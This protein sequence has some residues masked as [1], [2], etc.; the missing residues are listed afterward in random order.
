M[1]EDHALLQ[2]ELRPPKRSSPLSLR[3]DRPRQV[4]RLLLSVIAVAA[5]LAILADGLLVVSALGKPQ[6]VGAA[7]V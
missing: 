3:D 6:T 2:P 5:L 4:R 1:T 7:N